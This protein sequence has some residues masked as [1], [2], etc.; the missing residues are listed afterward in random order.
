MREVTTYFAL[1]CLIGAVAAPI[2][3]LALLVTGDSR[4]AVD[5]EST[6][7]GEA[8]KLIRPTSL[9]AQPAD[10]DI[11]GIT[12][13]AS[14]FG[15]TAKTSLPL[16]DAPGDP[17]VSNDRGSFRYL[18]STSRADFEV[19]SVDCAGPGLESVTAARDVGAVKKQA[20]MTFLVATPILCVIGFGLRRAGFVLKPRSA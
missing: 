2:F 11:T 14:E 16:G 12:C 6:P 9:W 10:V 15:G 17:S 19:G 7:A 5:G 20:A 8:V 1:L 18:T 4:P 13:T 3:A